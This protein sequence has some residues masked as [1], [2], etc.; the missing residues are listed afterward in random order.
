[1]PER[2]RWVRGTR[3]HRAT[4]QDAPMPDEDGISSRDDSRGTEAAPLMLEDSRAVVL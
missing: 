1:M 2:S 4:D 3:A